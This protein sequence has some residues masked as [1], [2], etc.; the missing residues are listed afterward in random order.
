MA[1]LTGSNI[2]QYSS[3]GSSKGSYFSL[4]NDRDTARVRFLYDSAKDIEGFSVHKV[5]VGDRDRYV[6]CLVDEGGSVADCPFCQAKLNK[7]AKLFVPLYNEDTEQIQTWERGQKF[8]G[9]I[10]GLCARYP[11]LVSRTFDIERHGKPKDT[12]TTY[13]IYP[14]GDADGTT[15]QDILDDCGV[16]ELANPLGTIILN[17][18]AEEMEYYLENEE[19]PDNSAPVR[20]R[21]RDTEEEDTPRRRGRGDRF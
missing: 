8:Y 17:K 13:D 18:T 21:G 9:T 4:K 15:V 1:R 7:F 3:G 12:G 2:E 10:S 11:N 5:K 19:F 14:V 20:R 16:E 6:N